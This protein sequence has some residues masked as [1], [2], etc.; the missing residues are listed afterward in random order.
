MNRD[1]DIERLLDEAE[2]HGLCVTA[3]DDNQRRKLARRVL[4]GE[5]T[6]PHSRLYIRTGMWEGLNPIMHAPYR[7]FRGQVRRRY[8]VIDTVS[9]LAL[10]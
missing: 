8:G 6:N 10:R 3:A 4:C 9:D 1:P 7:R 5:L 2:R